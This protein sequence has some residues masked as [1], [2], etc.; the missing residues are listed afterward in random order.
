VTAEDIDGIRYLW[1]RTPQYRGNGIKRAINMFAFTGQL[2]RHKSLLAG[3]CR[4]GVAIASSTYPLDAWPVCRIAR[5][6]QAKFVFEVHDLW[7]LSP[8][9]LGG[10]SP[11]NPF[12]RLL[13]LAE[14]FAYRNAGA[15]VSMLPKAEDHMMQHGLKAG[16]FA[17]IPNGIDSSEWT[18]N[19]T[20]LPAEHRAAFEDAR[21][22]R[23]AIVLYAGAHGIANALDSIVHAADLLREYPVTFILAGQGPEKSALQ[24]LAEGLRLQN[25]AF[26]DPVR[27]AE[28]PALLRASDIL[29][30]GLRRC[31][32]FRFGISPN[33][34]IDYMMAG[35]PIIQAINAGNDMVAESECGISVPPE[36]PSAIAN[37]VVQ[38]I[39]L[40]EAGRDRMGARARDYVLARHEY[41]VL[42]RRFLEVVGC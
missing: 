8:I 2:M 15:V 17:Y 4:H 10:M 7:P 18:G 32:L 31:P 11:G 16:K 34:L 36:D 3:H 42:A 19:L 6:A 29:F 12:I 30:I 28:V 37:A 39:E 20:E 5:A 24:G 38:L 22:K 1:F 13:Q 40:G 41:A 26:L 14:N 21:Q 35:R 33:K 27:K 9:E 23:H 25:L